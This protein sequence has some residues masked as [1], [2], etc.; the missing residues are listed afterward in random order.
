MVFEFSYLLLINSTLDPGLDDVAISPDGRFIA[1]STWNVRSGVKVFDA[2]TGKLLKSLLPNAKACSVYFDPDGKTLVTGSNTGYTTWEVDTWRSIG[3]LDFRSRG[4]RPCVTSN[5]KRSW[6][7]YR[8]DRS[9]ILLTRADG[10]EILTLRADANVII[11]SIAM[12]PEGDVLVAK[13]GDG[14]RSWDLAAVCRH[15][16]DLKLGSLDDRPIDSNRD[17]NGGLNITV[18]LGE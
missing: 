15:L 3:N 14:C 13:T 16:R 5:V 17:W 4:G 2:S 6:T 11:N 8:V 7:S 1:T 9:D 18:D 10:E 12:S